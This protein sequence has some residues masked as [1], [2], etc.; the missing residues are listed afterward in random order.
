[1]QHLRILL[2]Q[3]L[4]TVRGA[5]NSSLKVELD[6]VLLLGLLPCSLF[7]AAHGA[8]AGTIVFLHKLQGRARHDQWGGGVELIHNYF[9]FFPQDQYTKAHVIIPIVGVS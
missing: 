9:S 6:T 7:D 1:M 2:K 3:P 8:L 4:T 5:A